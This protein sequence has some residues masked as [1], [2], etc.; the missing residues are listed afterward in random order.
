[1][2]VFNR[3][4]KLHLAQALE[5]RRGNH[6]S[7]FRE[8]I[9]ERAPDTQQF[10]TLKRLLSRGCVESRLGSALKTCPTPPAFAL[11]I[12]LQAYARKGEGKHVL[13]EA[14]EVWNRSHQPQQHTWPGTNHTTLPL[15]IGP[16]S[17]CQVGPSSSVFS[18][19]IHGQP[20]K[21]RGGSLWGVLGAVVKQRNLFSCH[22]S[23]YGGA[24]LGTS[25]KQPDRQDRIHPARE[26]GCRGSHTHPF[27]SHA[28]TTANAFAARQWFGSVHSPWTI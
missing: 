4:L 3:G 19:P 27:P 10:L 20:P 11:T 6:N 8:G 2:G 24:A 18:S 5:D 17:K 7:G 25:P 14:L 1:M 21:Q 26:G 28:S 15:W 22:W 23:D 13:I 12:A 16:H 9:W